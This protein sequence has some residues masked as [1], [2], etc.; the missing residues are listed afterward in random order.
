MVTNGKN[1]SHIFEQRTAGIAVYLP[2]KT[3]DKKLIVSKNDNEN[4]ENSYGRFLG[5]CRYFYK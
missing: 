1:F 4:L 5:Y 3:I 2:V